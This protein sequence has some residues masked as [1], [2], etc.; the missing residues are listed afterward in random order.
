MNTTYRH[1]TAS[2]MVYERRGT[3]PTVVLLHGWCLNR[4]LWMYEEELLARTADVVTPDLPGFGRS[5]A[6]PGPHDLAAHAE[7]VRE[8]LDEIDAREV[9]LVGF[10]FGAAV[11]MELACTDD[12]R[13]VGLVLIGVTSGALFPADKMVRAARRDWPLFAR[14]SAEV[15]CEGGSAS[16]V[17]WV[18]SMFR[19]TNLTSAV[20][21]AE[22]LRQFEAVEAAQSLA[23][24]ALFLHGEEDQVSP[25]SIA[26]ESAAAAPLGQLRV[27]P[28][29]GHL[30]VL[31]DR[32]VL[33][34]VITDMVSQSHPDRAQQE[35]S[36]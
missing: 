4:S 23:V 24:P 9:V 21:A 3:G 6:M 25:A 30:L 29:S 11:A 15:L 31:D 5:D 8:L 20:D 16:T 34:Q 10:A 26:R 1:A 7:A 36:S 12:Q 33:H 13:V 2:G 27:V 32:E 22:L 14:R 28:G 18:E 35:V 17:D 19:A